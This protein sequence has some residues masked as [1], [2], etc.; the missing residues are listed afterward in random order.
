MIGYG[1]N[2]SVDVRNAKVYYQGKEIEDQY[3]REISEAYSRLDTARYLMDSFEITSEEKAF[4]I[5]DQ[6]RTLMDDHKLSEDE[7]IGQV[8]EEEGFFDNL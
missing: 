5:A 2:T 3:G 1:I 4:A 7:A 6:V 8:L